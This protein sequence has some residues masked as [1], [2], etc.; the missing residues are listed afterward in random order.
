MLNKIAHLS[1]NDNQGG[2]A[3]YAYR[4]HKFLNNSKKYISKMFVLNKNS[5]DTTIVKL[6]DRRLL[7]INKKLFFFF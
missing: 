4:T 5:N 7:K 3:L 6:N 1:Y 2:S